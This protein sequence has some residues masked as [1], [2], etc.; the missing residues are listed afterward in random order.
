[1]KTNLIKKIFRNYRLQEKDKVI[2]V[3]LVDEAMD[4]PRCEEILD[5]II[6]LKLDKSSIIGFLGYQL[7]KV[8]PEKADLISQNFTKDEL[9]IYNGF[10]T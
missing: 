6:V 9:S 5:F 3:R 8:K 10:K 4:I 1:M 7:F 2:I